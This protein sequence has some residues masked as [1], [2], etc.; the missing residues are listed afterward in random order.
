MFERRIPEWLRHAPA[1]S[2]R[3]FAALAGV[4]AVA[5]G[6]LV[7]VF[8]LAM[9]RALG[10]AQAVSQ[11]YFL[12]GLLSLLTGLL[13]PWLNR[14]VPR[15]W[16]YA[17]AALVFAGGGVAGM[18]GG[19][20]VVV[21]LTLISV[22]TVSLFVCFNAYVLDYVARV[23]LGRCETLRMFYSAMGWTLGPVLGVT[24]MEWW[25]PAPFL[26]SMAAAL[27]MLALFFVMRLGN[28][29][30]ITRARRPTANPLRYL[31]RFFAQPRLVV[32]WGFAVVRSC[33]WW[34]YVVYVP[35]FAVERGLDAQTG[36]IMLSVTNGVLFLTPVMLRWMQRRTVR[37]AVR[38]GFALSGLF[39]AAAWGL[40]DQPLLALLVLFLGSCFLVLLDICG[41][42]PFLMAVKPSER[43]EMSA[44][45]SSFRDVS[46]ILTPGA[47]WLVLL[48]APLSGVFAVGGLALGACWALAGTLH[49]RL[50]ARRIAPVAAE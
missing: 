17:C 13:L 7:S 26:V 43:T 19:H 32:G 31:G 49:P 20:W 38:T 15:R 24:L 16:L 4:E 33:G 1:P 25:A 27:A 39:F 50:G 46:G 5:R 44:V 30:L 2:L 11:V 34:I 12:I 21:S 29:K 47:A 45:Y 22:A 40:A 41:G 8:P 3:G 6:I 14:F 28:G 10:D 35:I 42:L 23:E 9:Y 37:A 18:A 48:W 36:G